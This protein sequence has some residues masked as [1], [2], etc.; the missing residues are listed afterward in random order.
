MQGTQYATKRSILC[1]GAFCG[2]TRLICSSD[3]VQTAEENNITTCKTIGP[4]R[5]K[6]G[7]RGRRSA[8]A[9][10]QTDQRI[11]FSHFGKYHI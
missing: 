10:A 11:C 3:L 7:L 9:S 8:W 1:R 5:K 4:R 6:P 2:P